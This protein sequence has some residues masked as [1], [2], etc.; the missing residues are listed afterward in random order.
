MRIVNVISTVQG[1]C[2]PHYKCMSCEEQLDGYYLARKHFYTRGEN[3]EDYTHIFCRECTSE[4]D[5]ETWQVH[6]KE[7]EKKQIAAEYRIA[8]MR[9]NIIKNALEEFDGY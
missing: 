4:T 6:D 7:L 8:Q 9:D 5:K 3:K 2:N 1:R